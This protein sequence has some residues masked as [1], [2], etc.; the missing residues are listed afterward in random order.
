MRKLLPCKCA[1]KGIAL[2]LSDSEDL[3]SMLVTI[4]LATVRDSLV[5]VVLAIFGDTELVL[6]M[7][8]LS[9]TS[10]TD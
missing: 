7:S 5:T 3:G 4:S 9:V 10:V 1:F 6:L 2:L 8:L